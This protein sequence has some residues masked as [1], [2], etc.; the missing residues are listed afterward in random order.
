MKTFVLSFWVT[1]GCFEVVKTDVS[2]FSEQLTGWR[3]SKQKVLIFNT[4]EGRNLTG[5]R[6][7]P[8]TLSAC[9]C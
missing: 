6:L 1:K 9:V 2:L 8:K 5:S 3:V 7:S 4:R